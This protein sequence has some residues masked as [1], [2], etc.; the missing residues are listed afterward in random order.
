VNTE[1]LPG[2]LATVDDYLITAMKL[3]RDIPR[4]G[5][6]TAMSPVARLTDADIAT[7]A[8]F[9]ASESRGHQLQWS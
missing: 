1:P 9:A 4:P 6:D 2:S 7:L 8:H 5:A 3:Y